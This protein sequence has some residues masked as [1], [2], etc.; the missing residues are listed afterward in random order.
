MATVDPSSFNKVI[1]SDGKIS[2]V[3]YPCV[4]VNGKIYPDLSPETRA[5]KDKADTIIKNQGIDLTN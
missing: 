2:S 4:I 3:D 1:L 5:K